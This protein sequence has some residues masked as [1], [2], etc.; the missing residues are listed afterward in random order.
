MKPVRTAITDIVYRGPAPDIGDLWCHRV[1][2]GV[3]MSVWELSQEEREK[4]IYGDGKICLFI[5]SEP[6]PPV[7]LEVRNDEST[8]SVGTHY[9]RIGNNNHH[10]P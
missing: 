10:A 5:W 8:K 3:I 2:P 1:E 9:H 6:I 7:S 4:L